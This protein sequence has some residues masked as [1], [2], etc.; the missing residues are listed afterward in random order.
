MLLYIHIPFC[1]S[2]CPYCAFG[3]LV[4]K[5]NLATDY[6]K[7]L[8]IDFK[9]Q[10][11]KFNIAKESISSL[12][13]G[14]GTPSAVNANLYENLFSEISPYLAKDCEI[15]SEA[16]PNSANL[17]WL[18][19]MRNLGV[20]RMSFGA[21]SFF[22]DKLKF[23]GRTH[24]AAQIYETVKNAKIAGFT[25]INVDLIYGTKFDTKKRLAIEVQNIKN[26]GVSHT[27]AYSLTLEEN[28]PFEGKI[29]YKKDSPLL[30]KFLINE[31][32][33]T[34]L[35]QYEISNFGQICRHNLGYWSGQEYLGVGVYAVG[36]MQGE[37]YT[38]TKNLSAYI[39]NPHEKEAE[40]LSRKD[41]NVEHIF[42]GARSIVGIEASK[43]G[44]EQLQRAEILRAHKK[45]EL[46]QD[47]YLVKNF[48][49]ADEIS[50]FI[51]G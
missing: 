35:K 18:K 36:F 41:L 10:A 17:T 12:F 49:L 15:T 40:I 51:V 39:K 13:I 46:R 23:L 16:N 32:E 47:R 1:E 19:K 24:S 6:F 33:K 43:L 37:R 2:K 20:N 8:I 48:L 44:K 7:A 50:L 38:N 31:I 9:A 26:L 14:G 29:S 34:D 45:L 3:S 27:S 30:A 22:E 5:E 4:G 42:L 25:N 21:Q 11:A 28:T